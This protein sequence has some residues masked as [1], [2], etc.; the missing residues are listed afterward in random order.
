MKKIQTIEPQAEFSD[1]L[2]NLKKHDALKLGKN[3]NSRQ[4]HGGKGIR[5]YAIK[6]AKL[7]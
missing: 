5:F 6:L 2:E 1:V 4:L 7:Q 3:S